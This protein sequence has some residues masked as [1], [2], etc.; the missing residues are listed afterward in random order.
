[1]LVALRSATVHQPWGS[2]GMRRSAAPNRASGARHRVAPHPC[3]R[4]AGGA[5]RHGSWPATV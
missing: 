5:G 1:M 4:G 2:N 3:G